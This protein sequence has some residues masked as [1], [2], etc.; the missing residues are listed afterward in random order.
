VKFYSFQITYD[1]KFWIFLVLDSVP[2]LRESS[3]KILP[4]EEYQRELVDN[5]KIKHLELGEKSDVFG[6]RLFAE[7]V[8]RI[9]SKF[10]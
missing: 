5:N 10:P 2:K 9:N 7:S 8:C 1:L 4:Y 3:Q 6:P